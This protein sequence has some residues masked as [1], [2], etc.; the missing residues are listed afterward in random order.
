MCKGK[1]PLAVQSFKSVLSSSGLKY[2]HV[3]INGSYKCACVLEPLILANDR[4][5]CTIN[6]SESIRA[7]PHATKRACNKINS[8]LLS[9][10]T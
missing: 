3:L 9:D 7:R 2:M 5:Q 10:M 6:F 1:Y 8:V 4:L